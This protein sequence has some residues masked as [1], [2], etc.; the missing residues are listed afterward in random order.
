MK[1]FLQD[2]P[3][4]TT[5]AHAIGGTVLFAYAAYAIFLGWQVRQGNGGQVFPASWGETAAQRHPAMMTYVL[6][7]L[8]FEI[9]DGLTLL[10]VKPENPLL[11]STHSS[12]AFI[13]VL[14]MS[15]VALVGQFAA[16][17]KNARDA[18]AYLGAATVLVLVAHAF[19][20]IRL[21]FSL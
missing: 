3:F 20:G 8:V 17:S 1:D 19:F 18:H 12:T 7:F 9:P 11:H 5:W 2:M 21:G 15:V 14:M 10:A 4:T 6:L 16:S 13:A